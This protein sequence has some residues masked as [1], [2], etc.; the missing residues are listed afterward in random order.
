MR[1]ASKWLA[2]QWRELLKIQFH[3]FAQVDEC[4]GDVVALAGRAGVQIMRDIA[5]CRIGK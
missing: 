2:P 4:F 1:L 5:A 3:R